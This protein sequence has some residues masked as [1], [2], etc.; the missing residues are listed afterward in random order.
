[1]SPAYEY[2]ACYARPPATTTV[3]QAVSLHQN[4][5]SLLGDTDYATFLQGSY[6]NDTALWDMNDVDI[7]AVTRGIY[8]GHFA[9]AIATSGIP[10]DEVFSRIERMLHGDSRYRGKWQREDKCI[11]LNTGVKIDIVPAVYIAG[12]ELDPVA[13]FSFS[14]GAERK[15]W[16]RD[17]YHAG[18]A[19]SSRTNGAYKQT[20][21]MLKRWARCCFGTRKVAPSYFLECAVYAQPDFMFTGDLERDFVTIGQQLASL[22]YSAGLPRLAGDGNLLSHNEW[23]VSRFVEFQLTL[24][25]ALWFAQAALTAQVEQQARELWTATFNGQVPT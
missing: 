19:K 17:H 25:K 21:R 24:Q 16:P 1:M 22:P 23:D 3:G 13:I 9:G 6:K 18:T 20:V 12:P 4:V 5:R 15:N 10:W 7:V 8:S 11:R 14:S 2:A